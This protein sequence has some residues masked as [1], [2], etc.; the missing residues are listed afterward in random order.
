M[1]WE[2]VPHAV[3]F[4]DSSV[5]LLVISQE[6]VLDQTAFACFCRE[7]TLFVASVLRRFFLS[8]CFTSVLAIFQRRLDGVSFVA[9]GQ[10]EQLEWE[11]V[12][13]SVVGNNCSKSS[14]F[15]RFAF[16]FSCI[17]RS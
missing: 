8:C 11:G 2:P 13:V 10:Q 9:G 7:K 6:T 3:R 16:S 1:P 12:S 5:D 15:P 4:T 17:R 14:E